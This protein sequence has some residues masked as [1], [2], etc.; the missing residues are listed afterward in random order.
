MLA[1]AVVGITMTL[2]APTASADLPCPTPATLDSMF[3]AGLPGELITTVASE[4]PESSNVNGAFIDPSYDPNIRLTQDAA[5]RLTFAL[6]GAGFRNAL[7]WFSFDAD[8]FVGLTHADINTNG[9]GG[10]SL[11]EL[12]AIPGVE[13][14]LVFGNVSAVGSGGT[15]ESGFAVELDEGRVFPAGTRIGFFLVQNGWTG[16]GVRGSCGVPGNPL[17]MYTVDMLNPESPPETTLDSDSELLKNRHAAMLFADLDSESIILGFEDLYRLGPS[18]ED[19]NDAV[20]RITS[21]PPEALNGTEI[22]SA[23]PVFPA[24]PPGMFTVPDC[25]NVEST[26][27]LATYLPEQVNVNAAYLDPSYDTTLSLTTDSALVVSFV[28]EGASYPNTLGYFTVTDAGFDGYT[29]DAID[30]D[31]DGVVDIDELA[32]LPSVSVGIIYQNAAKLGAGGP[33]AVRDTVIVE[34]GDVISSDRRIGFFLIQDGWAGDGYIRSFGGHPE[35]RLVFYTEDFLNPEAPGSSDATF[36]AGG[37]HPAKHAAMLFADEGR[38]D[39]L[40]A[41]EDLHRTDPGLNIHGLESDDDFNDV[42]FCISTV[43]ED[44]LVAAGI[45]VAGACPA[46]LDLDGAVGFTDLVLVLSNWG[47]ECTGS[48]EGPCLADLDGDGVVALSDVIAVLVTY[49]DC[50]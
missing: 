20:F 42:I 26:D 25:C 41:F 31:D 10:V 44:A 23:T 30:T 46:D 49:G 24:F 48:E 45:Y 33:L 29:K 3:D 12:E 50:P 40:L 8:T 47:G 11:A 43:A 4:L 6:E 38:E 37:T 2:G 36:R 27:I 21:N 34:G 13:T 15:L 14:G 32:A 22:P 39:V 7:G 28:D 18:D 1:G 5:V 17:V 16:S 9:S 19:F 35:G